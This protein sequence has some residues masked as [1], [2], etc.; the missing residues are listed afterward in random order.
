[1][2]K[3][4]IEEV[5]S[6]RLTK[7]INEP[8]VSD[9]RGDLIAAKSSQTTQKSMIDDWL[10]MLNAEGE[11]KP[12]ARKGRSSV[13]PKLIR[14]QAEWRYSALSEPFLGSS[15]MFSISPRTYADRDAA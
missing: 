15:D 2:S 10:D 7:W 12:K 3:N 13:Q 8:T 14:K 11:Y 6:L 5:N 1:M 4:E 9:L